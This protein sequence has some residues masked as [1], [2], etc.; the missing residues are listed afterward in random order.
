MRSAVLGQDE[1]VLVPMS[2]AEKG[3]H[4]WVYNPLKATGLCPGNSPPWKVTFRHS[5]LSL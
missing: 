5:A 2:R 4:G 3:A 1:R